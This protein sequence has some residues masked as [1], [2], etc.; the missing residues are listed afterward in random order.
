M[1]TVIILFILIANIVAIL[2][3]YHSFSKDFEKSKKL[4]YTMISMGVI[5]II[6]L[7]VYLLSTIGIAKEVAKSSKNMIIFSFV[8][9]NTIILLP[10]LIRSFY[11]KQSKKITMEKLN[12]IVMT[13]SIVAIILMIGEFCYFR[14][15]QKGIAKILED[16]K[17]NSQS[18]QEI[19]N[20]ENNTIGLNEE[21]ENLI[22]GNEETNNTKNSEKL[23]EEI[24]NEM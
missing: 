3:T 7:I 10:I 11:K 2:L 4:F 12:K 16:K 5:Y 22:S 13:M 21:I 1:N 14:N 17:S 15:I 18:N 24:V 20:K 19:T 23:N 6:T 8:P 9:V